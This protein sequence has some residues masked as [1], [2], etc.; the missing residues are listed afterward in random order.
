VS[1]VNF[2]YYFA[3]SGGGP[4]QIFIR[5][6]HNKRS[7]CLPSA[8]TR[9]THTHKSPQP[10]VIFFL[11]P[12]THTHP[13]FT[14]HIKLYFSSLP[15]WASHFQAHRGCRAGP[16]YSPLSPI[17]P[18]QRHAIFGNTRHPGDAAP[19]SPIHH[20]PSIPSPFHTRLGRIATPFLKC[21]CLLF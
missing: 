5:A 9:L 1:P 2:F 15:V 12:L 7:P 21:L 14:T 17:I 6:T 10:I 13:A 19:P 3:A 18:R 20:T 4:P 11:F 16:R 8:P